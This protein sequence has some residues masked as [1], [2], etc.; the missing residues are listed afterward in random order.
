MAQTK[1]SVSGGASVNIGPQSF[2]SMLPLSPPPLIHA[3]PESSPETSPFTLAFIT[4][5]IRVRRGCRQKYAKPAMPPNNLCVRHREW[6]TFGPADD[7][8]KRFGNVYFHYNAPCI[9]GVWPDFHPE[10]LDIPLS[11]IVQLMQVHTE[12]LRQHMPG[13]L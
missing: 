8:Q 11:M 1:V 2:M 9:Q 7:W 3:F 6:Q 10:Q 13:R 5:N 4:G 12:Y